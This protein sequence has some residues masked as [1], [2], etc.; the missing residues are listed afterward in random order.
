[1]GVGSAPALRTEARL[2]HQVADF[3]DAYWAV[4]L[5]KLCEH[6]ATVLSHQHAA[7]TALRR[8]PLSPSL[9][10]SWD[11]RP[12]LTGLPFAIF[13]FKYPLVSPLSTLF[14][15]SSVPFQSLLTSLSAAAS[16]RKASWLPAPPHPCLL[17]L[18]LALELSGSCRAWAFVSAEHGCYTLLSPVCCPLPSLRS[19]GLCGGLSVVLTGKNGVHLEASWGRAVLPCLLFDVE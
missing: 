18:L 7:E 11:S 14:T 5:Y 1:M 16:F 13:S 17:A 2:L 6:S 3:P 4:F 9:P 15:L 8:Q 19:H 12:V 10:H